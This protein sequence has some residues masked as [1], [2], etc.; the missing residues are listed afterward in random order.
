MKK[1]DRYDVS[2][3]VESQFE[4]GSRGRVLK[5]RLG[6]R[7]QRRMND[8]EAAALKAGMELFVRKYD[9]RHRF[10][11]TDICQMHEG[12]L[13]GIYDWA[14]RYRQV[15]L[16]KDGFAFAAAMRIPA[17]MADYER[18]VLARHTPCRF[19]SRSDI[20]NALAEAHVELV[21]VHPFREGNGRIARAL[22]TL[23]ALQAGLPP[24]DFSLIAGKRKTAYFAAVQA[25]M[26]RNYGLMASLFDETIDQ[27]LAES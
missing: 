2:D 5:N 4:P 25:G 13:S 20:V 18:T 12:W 9:E 14:G 16:S 26:D 19:G 22:S 11:A 8:A 7:S 24:L 27:T 15:N 23:M 21:L 6:I 17:L 1:Q 3:L 10:V